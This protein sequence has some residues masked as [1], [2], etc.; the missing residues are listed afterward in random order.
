MVGAGILN[1]N[2]KFRFSCISS[3]ARS[4]LPVKPT[5]VRMPNPHPYWASLQADIE[6]HLKE[7]IPTKEPLE[8]FEPMR[9]L[10]FAAPQT[11]VPVLCL[12]ACELVG[13]QRHQA[14]AAASAL[15]LNL[16]NAHAH[17]HLPEAER[18]EPEPGHAYG[19][20]IE[21]LSGDGIVPFG[22]ELLA[23]SD[24]PGH[25]NSERTLRVIIEISRAVGSGGLVEAQYM[26]KMLEAQLELR[27]VEL[28]ERV[29]EK[30]E[31]GLHAC[32]AACGA[33]LGG[34][35]EEE[36]E[37]LRKFG[38]CVGMIRGMLQT[39]LRE[40]D[41]QVEEMRNLALNQLQFFK[42]RDLDVIS[43]FINFYF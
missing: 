42:D 20:N 17:E 41:E 8:V 2:F 3:Q 23:R 19:P 11:T 6:A 13:G 34:G 36:I 16:A 18:P 14:M 4:P 27:H 43:S 28:M 25:G 21:L 7:A 26:K 24:G 33:V 12:A 5:T 38:F 32:G 15:L 30:K 22:F 37:T 1:G 40:Q 29:L 39:G 35:T 10:V 9:H 31:G